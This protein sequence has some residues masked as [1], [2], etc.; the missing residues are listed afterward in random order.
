LSHE[1]DAQRLCGS[2]ADIQYIGQR[3]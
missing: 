1:V 2:A 3:K